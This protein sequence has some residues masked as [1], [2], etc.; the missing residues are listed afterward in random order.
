MNKEKLKSFSDEELINSRICPI[1]LKEDDKIV[2]L[3]PGGSCFDCPE[4]GFSV[5][6]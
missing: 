5:C 1:C 4:C 6:D 2:K 3:T